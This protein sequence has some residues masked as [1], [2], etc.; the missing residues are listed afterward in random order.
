M[1]Y[2]KQSKSK[3][4]AEKSK[5]QVNRILDRCRKIPKF[6]NA[7][8]RAKFSRQFRKNGKLE[9]WKLVTDSGTS[10][11][12]LPYTEYKLNE[13]TVLPNEDPLQL[14]KNG[15]HFG[16]TPMA[17]YQ[18]L[19]FVRR[20]NYGARLFRVIASGRFSIGSEKSVASELTPVQEF[21]GDDMDRLLLGH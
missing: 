21:T 13:K 8:W 20:Q 11:P 3:R 4:D 7:S 2:L 10:S 1:A 6:L 18:F 12:G 16:V 17:V 15:L 14:C 19:E 5:E 9:G